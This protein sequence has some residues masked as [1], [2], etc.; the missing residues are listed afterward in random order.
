MR[1]IDI[2]PRQ[3]FYRSILESQ[4]VFLDAD[5]ERTLFNG[6]TYNMF[7][8]EKERRVE[9]IISDEGQKEFEIQGFKPDPRME[10]LIYIDGVVVFP[11]KLE[12][13]YVHLPNP[14]A[15][16]KEVVIIISGVPRLTKYPCDPNATD[17]SNGNCREVP[18]S[19]GCQP[20]Y[21]SVNLRQ[22][23][24]YSFNINYLRNEVAISLGK[25]LKRVNVE[26]LPGESTQNALE[27]VLGFK[28]DVFTVINGVLYVSYHLN[29][30]PVR[31]NYNYI[32]H[33]DGGIVKYTA[34]E[35][36]I[37]TSNCV[38]YNDRFFPDVKLTRAEF[39]SLIQRMRENFYNRYTDRGYVKVN[40]SLTQRYIRDRSEIVGR[41]YD[42]DVLS[43]LDEKYLD[44]C[45]VFPLYEDD[46]F[47]PQ[48]C[49][50]RAEVIVYL[51]RFIEWSLERFR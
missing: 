9:V 11:S 22:R 28:Q 27:R 29:Q 21:P 41:W 2:N 5:K 23:G 49:I 42:E 44:G 20:Q 51:H 50:T 30:V 33:N 17:C 43:S 14:I 35:R 32:D 25:T 8:D 12:D 13:D 16:N 40:K 19:S 15:G 26:L 24:S 4:Q 6:H 7:E 39:L 10:V 3:W 18:L 46:S 1:W 34:G 37:P 45:Y 38:L 31:I 36:V 47:N 48:A